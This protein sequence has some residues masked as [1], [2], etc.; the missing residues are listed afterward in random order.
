MLPSTIY[1]LSS[2]IHHPGLVLE[3]EHCSFCS[4]CSFAFC[5]VAQAA[6]HGLHIFTSSHLQMQRQCKDMH[7]LQLKP[8]WAS[9]DDPICAVGF[10]EM[11]HELNESFGD[12]TML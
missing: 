4:F 10:F 5:A 3:S 2:T 7:A 12:S 6:N 9:S 11:V 8:Q 1:H